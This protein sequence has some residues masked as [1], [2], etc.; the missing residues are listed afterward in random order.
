M[1]EK[2]FNLGEGGGGQSTL[3][4]KN[5][6]LLKNIKVPAVLELILYPADQ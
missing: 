2:K 3:N 1:T 4:L 6:S 5:V